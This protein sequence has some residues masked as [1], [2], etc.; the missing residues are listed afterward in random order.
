MTIVRYVEAPCHALAVVKA[1][2]VICRN[3]WIRALPAAF[4]FLSPG[5]PST[6]NAQIVTKAKNMTDTRK[7]NAEIAEK[8]MGW[9]LHDSLSA[10][11]P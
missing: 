11:L 8:V 2:P 4:L 6:D 10:E 9:E 3:L 5:M 7:L 1:F